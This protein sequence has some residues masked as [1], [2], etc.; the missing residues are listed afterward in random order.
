MCARAE[1]SEFVGRRDLG[2]KAVFVPTTQVHRT[3][4]TDQPYIFVSA[5]EGGEGGTREGI[6]VG[7]IDRIAFAFAFASTAAIDPMTIVG[8]CPTDRPIDRP[9]PLTRLLCTDVVL[10]FIVSL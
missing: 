9:L 1:G 2:R 4:P 5:V 6:T 10:T 7:T 3:Q 8:Y